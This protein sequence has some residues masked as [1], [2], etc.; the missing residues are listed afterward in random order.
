MEPFVGDIAEHPSV[1]PARQFGLRI[2]PAQIDHVDVL[3]REVLQRFGEQRPRGHVR[4][5]DRITNE[6]DFVRRRQAVKRLR[7]DKPK[8]R[9]FDEVRFRKNGRDHR[10]F[11]FKVPSDLRMARTD[12]VPVVMVPDAV[13]CHRARETQF[14]PPVNRPVE[15]QQPE[16]RVRLQFGETGDGV[17]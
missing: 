12:A 10:G 1:A 6:R 9:L 11:G 5:G 8:R 4:K 15:F 7:P 2:F 16:N 14:R 17:Q 13:D 3:S